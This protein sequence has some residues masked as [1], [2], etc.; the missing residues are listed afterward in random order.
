[1]AVWRDRTADIAG[2]CAQVFGPGVKSWAPMV[3]SEPPPPTTRTL[4]LLS[5]VAVCDPRCVF[6]VAVADHVPEPVSYSS[7]LAR[8]A[9][10]GLAYPPVTSTCTPLPKSVAV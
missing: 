10:P 3:R 8:E 5:S 1:V 2:V 9:W 4:P 6:M 7:Q